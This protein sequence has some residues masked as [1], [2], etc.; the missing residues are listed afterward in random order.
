MSTNEGMIIKTLPAS[1]DLSAN[2]YLFHFVD[3]GGNLA[4]RVTQGA[5]AIGVLQ[6]KPTA[7]GAACEVATGGFIKVMAGAA[8]TP[9]ADVTSDNAGK[10]ITSASG[11]IILGT[12][13]G[14]VA[15]AS[16]DII[17]IN[18]AP[19]NTTP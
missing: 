1:A 2:Q 10:C 9:G 17:T 11:N 8:I 15:A 18:F 14:S 7:L 5:I 3:T 4:K 19:R 12:Y 6:N 13:L 16:G